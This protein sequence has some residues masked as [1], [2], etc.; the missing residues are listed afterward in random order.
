[1]T[2]FKKQQQQQNTAY[3]FQFLIRDVQYT[4]FILSIQ[5]TPNM[6]KPW[7]KHD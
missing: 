5:P 4:M 1:M 3:H 7:A 6:V 2:K